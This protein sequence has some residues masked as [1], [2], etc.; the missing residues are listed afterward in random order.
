MVSA[1][2]LLLICILWR[3]PSSAESSVLDLLE[4]DV[5]QF[6]EEYLQYLATFAKATERSQDLR[7]LIKYVQTK[8]LI[9]RH[10]SKGLAYRLG[11]NEFA[12]L[13][14]H[15]VRALFGNNSFAPPPHMATTEPLQGN[16]LAADLSVHLDWSSESNPIGQ[17]VLTKVNSQGTCGACWAF[18]T[19]SAVEA[20]VKLSALAH[21]AA[22]AEGAKMPKA[23]AQERVLSGL[24][25]L[26]AQELI[27]CDHDF[28]NGCD[29]GNIFHALDYVVDHGLVRASA[30][31][32]EGKVSHLPLHASVLLCSAPPC[33]VRGPSVLLDCV[34]CIA[35]CV[36]DLASMAG[37]DAVLSVK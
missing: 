21:M 9:E 25:S 1:L 12:D 20:S 34:L 8:R 14:D 26:S 28:N 10:N 22:S 27:D 5:L 11:M 7:R 33:P 37:M 31:G 2:L 32:Y 18:A 16:A 30:Y 35:L 36:F 29:G 17:A 3:S 4:E 6:K 13:L 23:Q 19:A 24:P 15:E